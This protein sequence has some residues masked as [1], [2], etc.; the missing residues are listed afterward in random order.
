MTPCCV[1][2]LKI[3]L[4][5]MFMVWFVIDGLI[6]LLL[7]RPL[8][9][10]TWSSLLLVF[11]LQSLFFWFIIFFLFLLCKFYMFSILSFN[12]NLPNII[13]FSIWFLFFWFLILFLGSSVKVLLVFN[14]IFQSKLK[15]LCFLIWFIFFLVFFLVFCKSYYSF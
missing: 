8:K 5:S 4:L 11:Q 14:F 2:F 10:I 7:P 9:I 13:Y 1:L 3:W 12:L 15:V 6:F